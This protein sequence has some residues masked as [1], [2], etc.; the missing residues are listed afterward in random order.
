MLQLSWSFS[1][2]FLWK[3]RERF[4]LSRLSE[5]FSHVSRAQSL[6]RSLRR[7][8]PARGEDSVN[9]CPLFCCFRKYDIPP[10]LSFFTG[11]G[12]NVETG[13][14]AGRI[15]ETGRKSRPGASKKLIVEVH[16]PKDFGKEA[17]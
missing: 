16:R 3:S 2:R 10:G 8:L 15:K 17:S 11:F 14:K 12:Q 7:T 1:F 13:L 6:A 4:F 9:F 5:F